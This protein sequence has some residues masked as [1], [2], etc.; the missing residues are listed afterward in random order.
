MYVYSLHERLFNFVCLK[1]FSY[2]F[3]RSW[4]GK[5]SIENDNDNDNQL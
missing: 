4:C 2:S 5:T 3:I 1:Y